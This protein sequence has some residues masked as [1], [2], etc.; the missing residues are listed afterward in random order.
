VQYQP[1]AAPVAESDARRPALPALGNEVVLTC[2]ATALAS[3]V[4][5]LELTGSAQLLTSETYAPYEIFL[6]AGLVYL[7]INYALMRGMRTLEASL[8]RPH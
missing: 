5:L 4:T 2:K 7:A 1:A 3:T 8:N 6:A